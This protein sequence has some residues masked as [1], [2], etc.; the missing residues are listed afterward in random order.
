MDSRQSESICATVPTL[1]F[2]SLFKEV[3][4]NGVKSAVSNRMT[5]AV[6]SRLRGNILPAED[7]ERD[8][9]IMRE[10]AERNGF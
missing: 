8:A 5:F 10:I 2:L 9:R 6:R 7:A 1:K 4:N 3:R